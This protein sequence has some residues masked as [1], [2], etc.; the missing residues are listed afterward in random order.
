MRELCRGGQPLGSWGKCEP[1][2][3]AEAPCSEKRKLAPQ[4]AQ[5]RS[6]LG[7][8]WQKAKPR[9]TSADRGDSTKILKYHGRLP[10]LQRPAGSARENRPRHSA[11]FPRTFAQTPRQDQ[12][13]QS[14]QYFLAKTSFQHFSTFFNTVFNIFQR[15]PSVKTSFFNI[16]QHFPSAARRKLHVKLF[17]GAIRRFCDLVSRAAA[18]P[19]LIPLA[20]RI[21]PCKPATSSLARFQG[22]VGAAAPRHRDAAPSRPDGRRSRGTRGDATGPGRRADRARAAIDET[23]R[24]S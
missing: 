4:R 13:R 16:L 7:K 21:F 9:W 17:S 11:I 18:R 10:P 14:R 3:A 1:L 20:R 15:Q 19:Q 5:R 6:D 23:R 24:A 12:R 8:F 22:D 2:T